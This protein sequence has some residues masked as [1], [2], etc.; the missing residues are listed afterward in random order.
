[1]RGGAEKE[2]CCCYEPTQPLVSLNKAV[3]NPSFW[4]GTF[5]G[6]RLTSH[7]VGLF[8]EFT[9][10]ILLGMWGFI[11]NPVLSITSSREIGF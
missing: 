8:D 10:F 9:E 7:N 1:M 4:A 11:K 3:L 5:G 6:D 2:W